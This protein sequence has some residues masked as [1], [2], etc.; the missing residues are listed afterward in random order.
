MIINAKFSKGNDT[1][2]Y[3]LLRIAKNVSVKELAEDLELTP[4]YIHALENGSRNPSPRTVKD[5][6]VRFGV[7]REIIETFDKE[8]AKQN[9]YEKTLLWLLKTICIRDYAQKP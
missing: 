2:I 3:R 9:G 1:N 8:E 5:Y 6:S 4:A 7:P